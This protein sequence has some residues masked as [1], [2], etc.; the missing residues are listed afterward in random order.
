MSRTNETRF[1]KWHETCK[2]ICK[3]DGTT[4]NSKQR[5][6]ENKCRCESKE[7][8]DKSVCD[9]GFIW[10]PSN[11]EC[12]WK[13]CISE[14]LDYKNCKCRKILVDKLIDECAE[15]IDETKLANI[16]FT[17]NENSYECSSCMVYIV[18][19]IVVIVISTGI[20]VYLVY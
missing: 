13:L 15:T 10:N 6:K 11:C 3:L 1:I 17:E 7:L 2:C 5:W 18:L 14:H 12:E 8:I 4:C 19:M 9:K 20:T 16:T